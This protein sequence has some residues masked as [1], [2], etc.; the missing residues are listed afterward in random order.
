MNVDCGRHADRVKG[1]S[2]YT[3]FG[4]RKRQCERIIEEDWETFIKAICVQDATR[5]YRPQIDNQIRADKVVYCAVFG[6]FI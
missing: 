6:C 4:F 5:K 1:Q 2:N 3:M